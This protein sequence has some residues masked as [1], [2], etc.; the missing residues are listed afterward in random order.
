MKQVLT[1]RL[2]PEVL[3]QLDRLAEATAR[4]R[5]WIITEAVRDYLAVN[6]WHVAAID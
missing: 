3:T 2:D 4:Q 6:A 1:V 5:S